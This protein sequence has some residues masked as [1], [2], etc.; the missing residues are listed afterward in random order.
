MLKWRKCDNIGLMFVDISNM[1]GLFCNFCFCVVFE[2]DCCNFFVSFGFIIVLFVLLLEFS[3][4]CIVC[5][6]NC[7]NFGWSVIIGSLWF[8]SYMVWMIMWD[9]EIFVVDVSVLV[10]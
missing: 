9:N 8:M 3:V 7:F 6:N 2:I 1:V 4:C 5:S 10:F